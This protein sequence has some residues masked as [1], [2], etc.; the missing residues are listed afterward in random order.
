M[1]NREQKILSILKKE[2]PIR[3]T[4]LKFDSTFQLA[5]A[6]ILSAQCTDLRVN[7]VTKI[8][9]QKLKAPK[10]FAGVPQKELEALIYSTG[11]YRAKA[12]NIKAM[13]QKIVSE[14]K[15]KM[16]S[17]MDAL[18]SL[19]GVARKSANVILQ[20]GFGKTQGVVV[21][22]H[23]KRVSF[24]LGFTTTT[25]NPTKAE[26]EL[27]ELFPKKDWRFVGDTL[28]WHGRKVCHSRKPNCT[29]CAVNKLCPSAFTF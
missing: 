29:G 28:I 7:K 3:G 21:D 6:V 1:L 12:R 9:F 17:Q 11:F 26:C 13:A 18:L 15:G 22:T 14:H 27:M 19:P 24:R 8:L 5:V 2:H 20:E 23:I 10:D 16:P 25:I 4:A